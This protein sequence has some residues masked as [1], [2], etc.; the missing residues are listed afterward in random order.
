MSQPCPIW[1]G[2]LYFYLF[3]WFYNRNWMYGV[4]ETDAHTSAWRLKSKSVKY[5]HVYWEV[6]SFFW[7]PQMSDYCTKHNHSPWTPSLTVTP[8]FMDWWILQVIH[9]SFRFTS[10]FSQARNQ[11]VNLLQ[12]CLSSCSVCDRAAHTHCHNSACKTAKSDLLQSQVQQLHSL[13][14]VT[15]NL[16]ETFT[17]EG[18]NVPDV[19][20]TSVMVYTTGRLSTGLKKPLASQIISFILKFK[21]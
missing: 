20:S 19:S 13:L 9:F 6:S 11:I 2:L 18:K 10:L 1:E 17:W 4:Q 5:Y 21:A 3:G 12:G 16:P 8:G 15:H 7:C 14:A